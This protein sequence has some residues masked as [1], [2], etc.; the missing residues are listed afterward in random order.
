MVLTK[1][2]FSGYIKKFNSQPI[3]VAL[4]RG[5]KSKLE[6]ELENPLAQGKLLI[7]IPFDNS[8]KRVTEKLPP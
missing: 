4:A 5:L 3:I 7:I 1:E 8:V 2:E 6:P